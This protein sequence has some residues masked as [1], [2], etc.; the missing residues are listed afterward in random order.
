MNDCSSLSVKKAT[1]GVRIFSLW[2]IPI[3]LCSCVPYVKYE[4]AV[5]KLQRANRVNSDMEK[6]LRDTQIAGFDGEAQ[7]QRSSAR[8]SDLET[9]LA[10][11]T[12]ER[13]SLMEINAALQQSLN[14]IP[15]VVISTE[16]IAP[17]VSTNPETGGIMLRDD[18]LFDKGRSTLKKQGKAIIQELVNNIQRDYPSYIIFIDGHTDNTPIKKSKNADNWELGAK[19]AH[20]VFKEFVVLGFDKSLLRLSS[21]GW[22]MPVPGVN[23][24]TEAGRRQCR[25]VEIRLG[26]P[27]E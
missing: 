20:A 11:I 25:R 18:V 12:K 2:L 17:G 19:R 4:D 1:R 26:E 27:I 16:Q 10:A 22:A 3:L 5:S 23:P 24:D 7:L 15:K 9:N 13:D 8:I 6:R 21:S 14:D